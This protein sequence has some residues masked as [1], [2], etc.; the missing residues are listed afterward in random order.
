M[1]RQAIHREELTVPAS[2]DF[3]AA[4]GCD[5][6][7]DQQTHTEEYVFV[8]QHGEKSKLWIGTADRTFGLS[9]FQ[10]GV[11]VLRLLDECLSNV[12]LDEER[13]MILVTHGNGGSI[14]E[15]ELLVWPSVRA[16]FTR[17]RVEPH[18]AASSSTGTT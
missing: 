14:Q 3:V 2:E 15:L 9:V 12:R 6:D 5:V 18:S 10:N 4:F 13:Q 16:T 8:D 7:F 1:I 17:R 11:E